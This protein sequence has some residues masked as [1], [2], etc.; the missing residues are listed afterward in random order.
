MAFEARWV[1]PSPL[2]PASSLSLFSSC[3][4]SSLKSLGAAPQALSLMSAPLHVAPFPLP[5]WRMLPPSTDSTTKSSCPGKSLLWQLRTEPY[6]PCGPHTHSNTGPS[7]LKLPAA[8][9]CGIMEG[10]GKPVIFT[11]PALS[12][13]PNPRVCKVTE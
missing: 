4:P 11:S 6:A 9:H 2:Q 5:V 1:W 8:C 10:R 7:T 13:M 12:Y 3:L